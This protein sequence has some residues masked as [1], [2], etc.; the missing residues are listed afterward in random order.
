MGRQC[1]KRE[2]EYMDGTDK[3]RSDFRFKRILLKISGE[4][5]MGDAGFG[6]DMPTCAHLAKNISAS[7]Q[8]GAEICLV[9]GGGNIFRGLAKEY[10]HKIYGSINLDTVQQL[11]NK[12]N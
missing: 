12:T 5:L 11:L 6:I 1:E 4:V 10:K 8:A 7:V 3:P 2:P 9:I